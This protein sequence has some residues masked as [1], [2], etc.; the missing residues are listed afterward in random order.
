MALERNFITPD[1][2]ENGLGAIDKAR[3]DKAIDQIGLTFD[4][5]NKPTTE[6]V[7]TAEYL[8]PKEERMVK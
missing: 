7:F 3:M 1:V 6:E 4:Y 8:P 5:T 2:K